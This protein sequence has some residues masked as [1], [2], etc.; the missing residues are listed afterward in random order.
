MSM[1]Y[2]KGKATSAASRGHCSAT[3]E[4][5][6]WSG[7]WVLRRTRAEVIQILSGVF[8]WP[9]PECPLPFGQPECRRAQWIPTNQ[10][11]QRLEA[12]KQDGRNPGPWVSAAH[13]L[14]PRAVT[15][16]RS[17]PLSRLILHSGVS[18]RAGRT[19]LPNTALKESLHTL[20]APCG[21]MCVHSV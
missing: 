14:R 7:H 19:T 17:Q 20:T 16:E 8:G 11:G 21:G 13:L 18:F 15:Q 10:W 5:E 12:E 2:V 9:L 4:C 1:L 3:P 6:P